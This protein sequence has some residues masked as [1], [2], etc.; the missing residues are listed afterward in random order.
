M[1]TFDFDRSRDFGALIEDAFKTGIKYIAHL[2]KYLLI[3]VGP[4]MVINAFIMGPWLQEYTT[5]VQEIIPILMSG[6]SGDVDS[7]MSM[8]SS[9]ASWRLLAG[10]VVG[11]FSTSFAF[12]T[13]LG[14]Y[15][16]V[17][18]HNTLPEMQDIQ[19]VIFGNLGKFIG[20]YIVTGLLI[21][22]FFIAV[23]LVLGIIGSLGFGTVAGIFGIA[24]FLFY[25]YAIFKLI[26]SPVFMVTENQG[27][28]ESLRSSW[29]ATTGIWWK[30][31]GGIIIV[32]MAVG[33]AVGIVGAVLTSILAIGGMSPLSTSY[34]TAS[35]V[36]SN[37]LGLLTY[38]FV[39]AV[40]ILLYYSLRPGK[41]AGGPDDMIDQIGAD[42]FFG[43][44]KE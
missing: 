31:F 5:L 35:T 17:R 10:M 28:I 13:V 11:I 43:E 7:I 21:M 24:A 44:E 34:L 40:P 36:I 32:A 9:L 30:V 26:L 12:L 16:H 14:F 33:L 4:L 6:G 37:L 18:E 3:F 2:L 42:E 38:P 23:A 29:A 20:L 8:Y 25:I 27:I 41:A 15:N 39:Y 22:L 1:E 19:S